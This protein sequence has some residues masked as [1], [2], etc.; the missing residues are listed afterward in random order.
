M[1]QLYAICQGDWHRSC[2]VWKPLLVAQI[3]ER[4]EQTYDLLA[5]GWPKRYLMVDSSKDFEW[6]EAGNDVA[7][8]FRGIRGRGPAAGAGA[9][10]GCRLLDKAPAD[11]LCL[12][13]RVGEALHRAFKDESRGLG[14]LHVG[15]LV[16]LSGGLAVP[17]RTLVRIRD[18]VSRHLGELAAHRPECRLLGGDVREARLDAVGTGLEARQLGAHLESLGEGR[19]DVID[20]RLRRQAWK[21][22]ERLLPGLLDAAKVD[23]QIG[24]SGADVD[25]LALEVG[26]ELIEIRCTRVEMKSQPDQRSAGDPDVDVPRRRGSLG[27]SHP[28]IIAGQ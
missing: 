19:G 9:H 11:Q 8:L 1:V 23:E 14:V 26:H 12:Q 16:D 20:D 28:A 3:R 6:L 17:A 18:R 21:H 10:C 22:L 25:Q 5:A 24:P 7:E 4:P 15:D 13:R 2:P 27:G